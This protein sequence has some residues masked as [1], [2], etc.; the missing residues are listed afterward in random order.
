MFSSRGIFVAAGGIFLI[1]LGLGFMGIQTVTTMFPF[2]FGNAGGLFGINIG[3]LLGQDPTGFMTQVNDA[4]QSGQASDFPEGFEWL[5]FFAIPSSLVDYC[6]FIGTVMVIASII[7]YPTFRLSSNPGVIRVTRKLD[8]EK[9]FAGEFIYVSVEIKN[10][11]SRRLD[12]VEVYD[13]YPETFELAIGENFIMTQLEGDEVKE[14]SYI[15]RVPTRGVWKIGPTK[16][17]IH[18]R[19]G[20]YWEEDIR[21]FYTEVMVY[22]SYEDVRRM[23]ALSKKRQIG[24]MFGSHRTREKGAGDDFHSLRKYFP[25]DEFKKVDWKAFSRTNELMVREFEAEKN[26]RMIVFLDHSASMGGGTINNTKLDF[27]IRAAMLA[28]HMCRERGDLGGLITFSDRPT[29]YLPAE[30]KKAQFFQMLEVLALIEPKGSSNPLAA[31][32]YVMERLPRTS[33]FVF[34]TDL[35]T[36]DMGLFIEAVKRA[37]SAKNYITV[38]SPLGPLFEQTEELTQIERAMAE[39]ISEEFLHHRKMLED[40]LRALEV[41]IINVGPEDILATVIKAYHMGKAAGKGLI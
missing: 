27:A 34:L 35:E 9:A 16:V 14:Y 5:I 3:E 37:R 8:R 28:L 18:D 22:P 15:L 30:N 26:I 39:A 32:D 40:A 38:I 36:G 4:I 33:F 7:G 10:T 12:F 1:S 13:A 17:I 41:E 24:K 11:S 23:D 25:G 29:S 2:L 6:M 21:E 31:V 20:F 19:L